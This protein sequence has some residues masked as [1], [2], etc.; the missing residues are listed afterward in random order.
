MP[1]F[2]IP[3][4]LA[5]GRP[6]FLLVAF[7]I[8]VDGIPRETSSAQNRERQRADCLQ[9]AWQPLANAHGSVQGVAF[10]YFYV[11]YPSCWSPSMTLA[12]MALIG[13]HLR[14]LWGGP[15]RSALW[16]F[17]IPARVSSGF[18]SASTK[19]RHMLCIRAW[20]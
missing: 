6:P 11:A 14:K 12:V 4:R 15:L 19:P 9:A 17:Y 16:S 7:N 10:I 13:K 5:R 3:A 20:L 2:R 8:E 18:Q 1:I